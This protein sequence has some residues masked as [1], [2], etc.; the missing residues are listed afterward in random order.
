MMFDLNLQVRL[1]T[2]LT[3]WKNTQEGHIILDFTAFITT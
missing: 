3:I 1:K 2:Y